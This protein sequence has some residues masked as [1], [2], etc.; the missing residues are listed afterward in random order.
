[1]S[2]HAI[3]KL[4]GYEIPLIGIPM[5]STLEKCDYC[6]GKFGLLDIRFLGSKFICQK[7]ERIYL[8]DN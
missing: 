7:C 3:V 8:S 5:E 2:K 4:G 1:M 6:A